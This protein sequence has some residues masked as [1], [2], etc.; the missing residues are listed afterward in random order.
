MNTNCTTKFLLPIVFPNITIEELI[1]NGFKKA[2][3]GM[4]DDDSYD[5]SLLLVFNTDADEDMLGELLGDMDVDIHPDEFNDKLQIF[6]I[7]NWK[8]YVS[9]D[10]YFKFLNNEPKPNIIEDEL[11]FSGDLK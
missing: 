2:Y 5:D 9:E 6:V 7:N 1:A 11:Y 10:T 3:I 8:D 4:L